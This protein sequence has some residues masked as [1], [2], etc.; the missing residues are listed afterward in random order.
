MKPSGDDLLF[1][2]RLSAKS[3]ECLRGIREA[4]KRTAWEELGLIAET[5][6]TT[7]RP[8]THSR[9]DERPVELYGNRDRAVVIPSRAH[10]RRRQKR[11][12]REVQDEQPALGAEGKKACKLDSA[13]QADA[14]AA[15]TRL[16]TLQATDYRI[17]AQVEERPKYTRGRPKGGVKDGANETVEKPFFWFSSPRSKPP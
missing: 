5:K 10:D 4:G 8:G 11:I 9:A 16:T 13:C 2:R 15:A 6:P 17:E 3:T 14:P 12:E 1:I 7:K